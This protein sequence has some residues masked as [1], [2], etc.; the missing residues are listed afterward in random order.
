MPR[1]ASLLAIL[2][3]FRIVGCY[4]DQYRGSQIYRL[5]IPE[6]AVDSVMEA[7]VSGEDTSVYDVLRSP[8][9][10]GDYADVM[11]KST[12]L[13]DFKGIITTHKVDA[14]LIDEDVERSIRRAKRENSQALSR[15][16]SRRSV[17]KRLT[18]HVYLP[19]N[20][21][22]AVL[23]EIAQDYQFVS[24]EELG[25]TVENRSIWLLKISMNKSLPIIW[26]DAGI[27]A[28]EWIAP[29]TAFYLI[30]RLLS[31]D[32]AS[33]LRKYQ[34]YI[35]PQINPD[36]YVYSFSRSRYW[37]KNRNQTGH[38]ECYGIDLNRNFPFRWGYSGSS[39]NPCSDTFKGLRGGDQAETRSIITKLSSIA[40]QTKLYLTLHSYGQYI[41]TPYGFQ[42][43]L[44][45]ANY[46]ELMR[47][48][49]K[50]IYKV[51]KKCGDVYT[52]GSSADL[53]Y[54]A[55]GASDDFACGHL[56]IPYIYTVELP[57][58]GAYNFLLPPAYIPLVGKEM[59]TALGVLVEYMK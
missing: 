15:S 47:L 9:T 17:G 28:R 20:V 24:L 42:R 53:L 1:W 35:A 4:D 43:G 21:M 10:R 13:D 11:V 56:N 38:S 46:D 50:I 29:A 49:L 3:L 37:R 5:Q 33:M 16:R 30:D 34:F 45:P 7:L 55:S 58:E 40:N 27:H 44:H 12:A 32:G 18:H 48:A 26:I 36:G 6:T 25:K 59:W 14:Q 2:L 23:H 8:R 19:F 54:A 41:L 31:R 39:S 57:D 22:E 52:T 51:W